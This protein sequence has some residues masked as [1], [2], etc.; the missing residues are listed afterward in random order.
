MRLSDLRPAKGANRP[1]KRRG[2]GSGSGHGKT[3]CRGHKG[4]KSRSGSKRRFGFEGGQMPL[5]RRIPKRGF[6]SKFPRCYQIVN[7]SQLRA[8]KDGDAVDPKAMMEKDIIKRADGLVKVLG[9]GEIKKT[10]TVSAHR[11]SKSA[12]EKI[13]KAGGKVQLITKELARVTS[14]S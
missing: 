12:K 7:L 9:D 11:F 1:I 10:L 14:V 13:E 3:S 4:A 5:I 2:C 8:F 6:N